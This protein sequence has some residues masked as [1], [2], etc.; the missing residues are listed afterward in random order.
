MWH[1]DGVSNPGTNPAFSDVLE[2]TL[3][4]RA[5]LKGGAAAAVGTL[6]GAPLLSQ[7]SLAAGS[8]RSKEAPLGA[9]GFQSVPVSDADTVVVP[10]GYRAEVLFSW[11][12]PISDASKVFKPDASNTAEEQAL[13]CGMHNDGMHY[14]PLNRRGVLGIIGGENSARGLLVI[15]HEYTDD[16]LLHP[17]GMLTWTAAKV[18]KSQNAHGVSVIEVKLDEASGRWSVVRPSSYARRITAATPMR[19]GGPARGHVL[20]TTNADPFART[21]L[22]TL[23]NCGHGYTP[24]G[25]YLACEENFNG[26][27]VNKGTI[28]PEQARYGIS[29]NGGGYRWHEFDERFDAGKHPN[30][31]NRHGWVVEIDPFAP[32]STPVKRTALGR[33]KHEG[34]FVTLAE[35]GRAV[36]YMGDDERFE[37]IYKFV[38]SRAFNPVKRSANLDLLD[39]GTLYVARFYDTGDGEWLPLTWGKNGLTPEN[40]FSDQG[41]VVIKAR[42]AA[43][44]L[45]ATRMDRPEWIGVNSVTGEVYCTLTNNS[46]RGSAGRAPTD[47]ANPRVDNVFGHIIRWNEVNQDAGATGFRWDLLVQCGDPSNANPAKRGDIQGD[48]F[49]SPDGLW[50]DERGLIWVQTDISTSIVSAP[51][52]QRGDY[53]N[54]GN[55]MM[56]AGDPYTGEFR[57]FLTGPKG[58]E[59][60]GVIMT[61]DMRSMFINVQHPGEPASERNDPANPTAISAWPGNGARPRSSTVVIR[62]VDGGVI[63]S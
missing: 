18:R 59:I 5:L 58:C 35:D 13:Q 49:G 24:W 20:L 47:P 53:R 14:F 42:Q 11:G 17:D 50:C 31:V 56:L 25:T 46:Q 44:R 21:V 43:D 41:E 60:T 52:E 57:R 51:P 32:T 16:G 9:L 3:K 34:A 1:D 36:V 4:R 7:R 27:F 54:I 55:N 39:E 10:E 8:V 38:S 22:G 33:F 40:G 6:I 26:Y 61:P 62:R 23:N 12:D 30:E 37:Y 29:A 45:G 28:P 19:I 2:R 63:G 48:L 15:N